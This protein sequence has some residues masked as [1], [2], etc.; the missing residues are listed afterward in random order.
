MLLR[1]V[2]RLCL[3]FSVPILVAVIT[4]VFLRQ[5]FLLPAKPGSQDKITI[6]IASGR[7]FS[8][9]CRELKNKG[10][11]RYAWSLSTLA[12]FRKA[13]TQISAG[14]YELSPAMDPRSILRKLM[15]GDVIK[16]QVTVK[17]GS[18]IKEIARALEEAG[19]IS[20]DEFER[21]AVEPALL[22][23]AGISASSFEGYLFPQTYFFSRPVTAHTII[24]TML[25][26]GEKQW[27]REF[28]ERTEQLRMS[29]HEI[30]TLASIIE[31]EAGNV[32]EQPLVSSVFHN[33]LNQTMKLQADPTVIYGLKDFDGNLTKE[34]LQNPHPY[35]T[36]VNLGLP[37]GPIANPGLSAIKAALYP[38]ETTFLFFVADGTGNHFFSTTLA[39]HNDAVNRF[40]RG[41]R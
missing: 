7:I 21:A 3:I 32:E 8:E 33:R 16:R 2:L 14:E 38:R 27:L 18:T 10:V 28:T 17:E 20:A 19:L 11:I 37:P 13:D 41:G 35:N 30:L 9:I 29:R 5:A 39:E 6:E 40:Q 25:E 12:R 31:R 15:S 24:W 1:F 36:Y 34:D 26:E 4:F 22:G 23:K